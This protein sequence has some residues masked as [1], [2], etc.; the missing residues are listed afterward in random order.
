MSQTFSQDDYQLL[1]KHLQAQVEVEFLT[2]P[3]YLT[4]VYSFTQ[5]ALNNS[6]LS[7]DNTNLYD[8]QQRTLS[9]AVQEMYHLQLACNLANAFDVTP[10]IPQAVLEAGTEI[11]IPHL[12][13]GGVPLTT[14]LGNLPA[15]IEAMVKIETPDPNSTFPPPNDNV[16]Y[17]S[18]SDLY[19]ATLTLL[20]R[21]LLAYAQTPAA[22]DP[23]FSPNR[24]QVAWG[25]FSSRYTYNK[26]TDR[27]HVQ[28][29]ANA[30]ADQ[31]EGHLVAPELQL[32]AH[33]GS[34][35]INQ[36]FKFGEGGYVLPEYQP[37]AGSRFAQYDNLTHYARF[38]QIKAVVQSPPIERDFFYQGGGTPSPDLPDWAKNLTYEV[39]QS[40]LNTIWSY[41][42]D[43]MQQG[44]ATGALGEGFGN[45][46]LSVKYL[47]PLIW[48][49]GYCPSYDYRAGVTPA[50]TQD[51]MDAS[52]PLCLFHWDAAT[53]EVR[54][55]YPDKKNTCE[56]LNQCAGLGWGGL[57]TKVGD[58]ACATADLH[59][60]QGTN[61]C[62]YQ[63]GCGYLSSIK[64]DTKNVYLPTYEQW[65]PGVNQCEGKG[66]CQVPI[67]INQVFDSTATFDDIKPPPVTR[68]DDLKATKQ[69]ATP[70]WDEARKLLQLM[71]NVP[72]ELRGQDPI[73]L[74]DPVSKQVQNGPDYDGKKRRAAI[75]ASSKQ[76]T[77]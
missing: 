70:V 46:M 30:I 62:K 9:V 37:S 29:L 26:I 64:V 43:V 10:A 69:K 18:I 41:L 5:K 61:S 73:T 65:I 40:S 11:S 58:G 71:N 47:A 24:Y 76:P 25:A 12:A 31:G 36:V 60:C 32:M 68:L 4:A 8:L 50:E 3:F 48:Q 7:W 77:S 59:T 52:D 72:R 39:V 51:A 2:V 75:S 20:A 28:R 34:K 33:A 63:A 6:T 23:N 45:A 21:Y 27:G 1:Q 57:G 19:H 35:E 14:Q 15:V 42:V 67:A 44:F 53:I 54:K 17:D 13:P 22:L 55:E 16:V 74:P 49:F 56:G 38:E 66:G